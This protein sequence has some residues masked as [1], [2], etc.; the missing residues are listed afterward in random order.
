MSESDW[1]LYDQAHQ[2]LSQWIV[3]WRRARGEQHPRPSLTFATHLGVEAVALAN[4]HS[5]VDLVRIFAEA[6]KRGECP[7]GRRTSDESVQT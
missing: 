5:K 3:A 7:C 2:A 1:W 4:T 6:G